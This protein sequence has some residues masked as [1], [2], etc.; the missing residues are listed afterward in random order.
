MD[1][2]SVLSHREDLVMRT[3]FSALV[4]VASMW[5]VVAAVGAVLTAQEK[6]QKPAEKGEAK[7]VK[8][9]DQI[10]NADPFDKV[11]GESHHKI[12]FHKM[13]AGRGYRIDL[14]SRDFDAYLRVEDPDGM[15]LAEN[16]DGGDGLN[17]RILFTPTRPGNY[18][19]I[20]TTLG[21]GESGFFKLTIT[22]AAPQ[23]VVLQ[24]VDKLTAN[25]PLDRV[26]AGCRHK[27]YSVKLEAGKEYTI[28][29]TSQFDTYL[30]LEDAQQKQLAQ[31]DDGG[32]GL[33]SRIV[34]QPQKTGTYRII[35][36]T[37]AADQ[38][39]DFQLR[40]VSN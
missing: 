32:G 6:G 30:R 23:K 39:G 17:S 28:D 5:T 27:V 4:G 21:P 40:I 12:Y 26:R 3:G 22:P 31:D 8:Y 10:T 37:F 38:T 20:A 33:N 25:D 16:D 7:A 19:I 29:M 13:E 24:K 35:A 15:S 14:E 2:I 9:E 34:F 18:R 1:H 11:R 36:T